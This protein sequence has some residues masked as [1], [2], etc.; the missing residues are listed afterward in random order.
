M[1]W[2]DL[3]RLD[4]DTALAPIVAALIANAPCDATVDQLESLRARAFD[5]LESR[6]LPIAPADARRLTS[7]FVDQRAR[8]MAASRLELERFRIAIRSST[9][10]LYEAKPDGTMTWIYNSQLERYAG[11]MVGRRLR[12]LMTPAEGDKLEALIAHVVATGEGVAYEGNIEIRGV[13]RVLFLGFEP[14][15]DATGTIVGLVGS[16]VDITEP[17]R[18]EAELELALRY[19]ETMMGILG[20]DLRNPVG[21]IQG[22]V[23]LLKLDPALPAQTLKGL[24]HIDKAARRI[25]EM[26]QT[27]LDFTRARHGGFPIKR[28]AMALDELCTSVID[29]ALA[30]SP[31]RTISLASDGDTRGDWD[32]ARLAQVVSN[33]VGNALVHGAPDMPIALGLAGIPTSVTL[34][35]TNR[36]PTLAAAERARLFEPFTRGPDGLR[37][38]KGLGL[39]LYIAREIV[40][41]HAGTIAVDSSDGTTVFT[42]QLP[43]AAQ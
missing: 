18:A 27:V 6:D 13:K 11:P 16:S 19:R 37:P 15:R 14:R 43:R 25:G 17:K 38:G 26:I 32:Q 40:A 7:W 9:I 42:V 3:D 4:V 8:A 29:E 1:A 36:G 35:V 12:E 30:A 10:S 33:L 21:A 39:G 23:G 5:H 31:D 24:A 22:V 28:H 2:L 34:S 41:A 20:H